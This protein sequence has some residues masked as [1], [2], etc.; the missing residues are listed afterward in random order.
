MDRASDF[1]TH[2][3]TTVRR[4]DAIVHA[5]FLPSEM[6]YPVECR[7]K[8]RGA[9]LLKS[10]GLKDTAAKCQSTPREKPLKV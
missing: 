9:V 3:C 10:E 7:H 2:D 8:L 4:K 5:D 1:L 6:D